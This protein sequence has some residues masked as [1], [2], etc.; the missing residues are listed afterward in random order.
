[1][2]L[3][4]RGVE[5]TWPCP[6]M[7]EVHGPAVAGPAETQVADGESVLGVRTPRQGR[8]GDSVTQWSSGSTFV[9]ASPS[10]KGWQG[11]KHNVCLRPRPSDQ[12]GPG[13]RSHH[14]VGEDS[15][16]H[17]P[18]PSP[19]HPLLC[20]PAGPPHSGAG[21]AR[22]HPLWEPGVLH[23]AGTGPGHRHAG[24]LAHPEQPAKGEFEAWEGRSRKGA[25]ILQRPGCE[26]RLSSHPQA[27]AEC[28]L[29]Q[30]VSRLWGRAVRTDSV[31]R[32]RRSCHSPL[33]HTLPLLGLT[34]EPP[35]L[36]SE[37]VWQAWGPV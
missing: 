25:L 24:S 23:E 19:T 34:G 15:D 2:A 3:G 20:I 32:R 11:K 35:F 13:R 14:R 36:Y 29:G 18:P 37:R 27:L 8:L 5:G 30:A 1:M 7:S 6:G 21:G 17:P 31:L 10:R 28:F 16:K 4:G 26:V 12:L 22:S 33:W 9:L